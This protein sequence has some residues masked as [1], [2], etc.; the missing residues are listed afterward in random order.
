MRLWVAQ[1]RSRRSG[2][3]DH[4]LTTFS[5]TKFFFYYSLP[6]EVVCSLALDVRPARSLF[7]CFRRL[8]W[9]DHFSKADYSS[10]PR[11]GPSGPIPFTGLKMVWYQ[12][13]STSLLM[14]EFWIPV[15]ILYSSDKKVVPYILD[16]FLFNSPNFNS[17]NTIPNPNPNPIPN[18]NLNPIIGIRRIEIRRIERTPLDQPVFCVCTVRFYTDIPNER[19]VE[20]WPD[21]YVEMRYKV[22]LHRRPLYYVIYMILPA[23]VISFMSLLG[24]LLPPD[25]GEKIGLGLCYQSLAHLFAQSS[26]TSPTSQ[27][28]QFIHPY[29][30]IRVQY[31]V[32]QKGTSVFL[33]ITVENINRFS[34][35]FHCWIWQ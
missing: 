22:R 34:N 17:P 18:P 9:P 11:P 32:S 3:S 15:S 33:S 27:G 12:W 14:K 29:S 30:Y 31:T 1:G 21:P 26:A 4:G 35:F 8:C 5:A 25:T 23:T 7:R 20:Y 19:V 24:F 13:K 6:V 2:R 28:L 16:R 10:A